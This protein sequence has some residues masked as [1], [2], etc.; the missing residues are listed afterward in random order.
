[1][2]I[3]R[4]TGLAAIIGGIFGAKPMAAQAAKQMTGW[5]LKAPAMPAYPQDASYDTL[6]EKTNSIDPVVALAK[7]TEHIR[8][9]TEQAAGKLLP[10][11]KEELDRYDKM[12]EHK[13]R[14]KSVSKTYKQIMIAERHKQREKKQWMEE[15]KQQLL[16]HFGIN[17]P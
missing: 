13:I 6:M 7:R 5:Q 4:R 9:L 8:Q 15:A 12:H 16:R 14:L 3:T 10:Y 17:L 2:T 1:M 11:Q